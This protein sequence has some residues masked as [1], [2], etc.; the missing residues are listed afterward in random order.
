MKKLFYIKIVLLLILTT[1][2]IFSVLPT[3]WYYYI[4]RTVKIQTFD[5]QE[6][7]GKVTD[8]FY[9][10]ECIQKD[11]EGNCLIYQDDY[12]LRLQQ[13]KEIML[14]RCKYINKIEEIG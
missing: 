10:R 2:W 6:Y 14:F 12:T 1:I 11:F 3:D 8:I 13:T 5:Q 7:I 9:F 4:G